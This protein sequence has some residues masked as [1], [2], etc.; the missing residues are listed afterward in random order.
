MDAVTDPTLLDGTAL[1][2][3]YRLR[4][5]S[6]VE[7]TSALIRRIEALEPVLNA[8]IIVDRAGAVRAAEASAAR[9]ARGEPL[10]ALDGVPVTIKDNVL[11]A[12]HPMRR[13]SRTAPE[14]PAG[15]SAPAVERLLAAGAVPLGKTTMPEF[16]WKGIGDSPLTGITRNP[17]N[18]SVTTGGSSAGAAA[19]AALNLGVVHLGTDGAGSIRIPASFCGVFGIKPSFG[20]VPA[21]P[22]S[23]F[24]AVSHLGPLS[25]TVR[26]A[27][28]MVQILAGPDPR[29][30]TASHAPLPDLL[31]GLESGIR[32]LRV[33]WSPRLGYVER[34]DPEVEALTAAAA[35][36]FEALGAHVEEADPGFADPTGI[37][38][39]LWWTGAWAALRTIPEDRWGEMDPGFVRAALRGREVT[40]ADFAMALNARGP[41][42]AAMARFHERYDLLLTPTLATPAFETGHDTPPDG[43]FGDD[44]IG[45]SPYSYPF[46]LSLQPAASVPCGLTAGGLPVGLQIV[47]PMMREDLVLRAARAFEEAHPWSF[48]DRPRGT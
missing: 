43:R 21:Y 16:G 44:W 37:L 9:W 38:N 46:N 8:F 1:R 25:R 24:A 14:T 35:R 23:A 3:A 36:R 19:A 33:A 11:W 48:I 13:G 17:W 42:H 47:G 32:G 29:D 15:E 20:R 31:E 6:P 7:V 18:T 2:T 5:L 45:W 22:P 28:V 4:E 40:G 30:I 41:L 34:L 12:G 10:S 39:P 26:D 27:A